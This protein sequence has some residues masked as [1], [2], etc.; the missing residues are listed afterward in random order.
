MN[1]F[2]TADLIAYA[3]DILGYPMLA[4]DAR[5]GDSDLLDI[6]ANLVKHKLS[7]ASELK[8]MVEYFL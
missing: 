4:E 8:T 2:K 3:L 5:K 6:Y 7:R 1:D